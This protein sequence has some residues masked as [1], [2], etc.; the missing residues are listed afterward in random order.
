[1][2][3]NL[4][5]FLMCIFSLLYGSSHL[6]AQVSIGVN[7]RPVDGA[8][9]QLKTI[10]D[11]NSN[12]SINATQ[13][14]GFPRVELSDNA[15]LYPMFLAD[16]T[17]SSSGPSTDYTAN[18]ISIDKAH[19]GLVV[20]NVGDK[21][22]QGLYYWNGLQWR[23]FAD[24]TAEP[25]SATLNCAGA[26]MTPVQ[27]ITGGT[28]IIAGTVLQVPYT[29]SNGGSFD[30]VTLVST[31]N[32]NVTATI[33][34]GMLSAGNGV[35]NFALSGVPEINQQAPNGITF[36]LTPF[37]TNNPGITGCNGVTVGNVLTASHETTAVMGYLMWTEDNKGNDTG[38]TGYA[39][40][41]NSPDGKFSA[42]VRVPSGTTSI[43]KGNQY[44][45]IQ[46]RNNQDVAQTVIWN[47]ST[48]YS[49][50]Q[51]QYANM[52]TMPSQV[53][54]GTRGVTTTWTNASSANASDGYW[55]DMGIYD[56]DG[57]EYRRY[58]WIPLGE[59]NK[60]SYEIHVMCALDTATP[61]IAV[62]PTK[63]KV[64]IKFTQVTAE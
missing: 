14:L 33:V 54:G 57:P 45:N 31:G 59:M 19:T 41:C 32:P 5:V 37:L 46:V 63:L 21:L 56:G 38:T 12:G 17:D 55:A 10:K 47:Y 23:I 40:Q 1:M 43:A 49:G 62:S 20:Y 4:S 24:A 3:T 13:G 61:G 6:F 60:V 48:V 36:D 64:Y 22:G 11:T 39:L 8:I 7:E 51:V 18:K 50:G 30:G 2:K 42:R 52:F 28:A 16:P 9:L 53:W 35:L 25:A 29:G 58:T 34:S 27:Q 26:T 44:I 15:N